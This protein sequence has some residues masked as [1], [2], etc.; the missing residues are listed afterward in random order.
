MEVT[1]CPRQTHLMPPLRTV[2]VSARLY[3]R[4]APAETP[5]PP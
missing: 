5:T 2:V 3:A 4:T 1:R